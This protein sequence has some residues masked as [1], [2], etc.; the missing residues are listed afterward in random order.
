M[1]TYSILVTNTGNVTINALAVS[2]DKLGA[3]T[4]PVSSLAPAAFTTCTAT[5]LV[6][7]ATSIWAP[8]PTPP[9]PTAAHRWRP[10]PATDTLTVAITGQAPA[11]TIDKTPRPPMAPA[12]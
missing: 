7:G 5:H 1:I 3:I 4:C 6:S 10:V 8:S 11:L 9:P 12:T 2:D